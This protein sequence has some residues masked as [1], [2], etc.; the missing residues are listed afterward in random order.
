M[1]PAASGA[2]DSRQ[3]DN[4]NRKQQ[5]ASSPA[6]FSDVT[7]RLASKT[8]ASAKSNAPKQGLKH[9]RGSV[10]GSVTNSKD[11]QRTRGAVAVHPGGA[12]TN[13][14]DAYRSETVKKTEEKNSQGPET[15]STDITSIKVDYYR[16][17]SDQSDTTSKSSK[18]KLKNQQK[19]GGEASTSN[20]QNSKTSVGCGAVF[21]KEGCL[22]SELIQFHI[23]KRLKKGGKMHTKT[24]NTQETDSQS[25]VPAE[26]INTEN[27]TQQDQNLQNEIERLMEENEDFKVAKDV[28]VRLHH[29]LENVEEKRAKTEEENEKLRQQFIEVEITKQALQN[30]LEKAKEVA[31]DVSVRL[32]HELENVEEKRAKT[33]EENEK[34]RQQFI[35]VEITKQALQN[36]LEKA[37]EDDSE[38]LKCQLQFIKEEA[39]LMRKK[40]AKIDKEKDRLEQELQKYRS[41]YGDLDS[42]LPKGEAGGPPTTRESELKL[43]LRL[44]EEEA[45]ILGRKI[46]ELE[47]ENRGLKAEL[48]DLRGD[49][50]AGASGTSFREQSEVSEL[51]QQL[52]LVEDEAELLR[53]NL[54]D[55]ED[56]NKKITTEVNKYKFKAGTH[57]SSRHSDSAKTEVLQEE[58]KAARMQINELSGK[59]M[60]LQYE[61]RV[62]MSNMQRYDLASHL[63]IRGSPRDSDTESDA[64]KR[65]SDDDSR[66][67]HRKR[68]GPIGGESD[69]EEVRN[70]RCLT[71]TRS[72]Y[73]AEGRFLPQ[74]FKDRQ[75]MIDIRM[76]A[77]RLSRTIDR[78]ISD[79]ST[80]ITE[81]R[82][83]VT[84]GDLFGRMDEEDDGSRIREHEL[85]Y[86]INAQMKAFQ[87]ELQTFIDRLEVPKSDERGA[88]EPLSEPTPGVGAAESE[89]EIRAQA[90]KY[91]LQ[92]QHSREK[93]KCEELQKR[94]GQE[95][96]EWIR[97]KEALLRQIAEIQGG[98]NR[99]ILLD[100]KSVL[101]EVQSELKKEETRRSDLQ[102]LYTRDRCAWELERAELKCRI[103]LL[104]HEVKARRESNLNVQ[105]HGTCDEVL[106]LNLHSPTS[107]SSCLNGT[108]DQKLPCISETDAPERDEILCK[109]E[110]ITI[111]TPGGHDPAFVNHFNNKSF[112]E[113][114]G[115]HNN[116]NNTTCGHDKKKYTSTLNAALKEIAKVS[117]E[118]CSYQDEIRQKSNLSNH[119]Y[120]KDKAIEL[121]AKASKY[122][123][124]K[125]IR[126]PKE[127]LKREREEQKRLLADTHTAAMDLRKQLESSERGW[128]REKGELLQRFDMERKEWESQL[129]DMQRKIEELY[130]EVK[131][132]RESNL[133]V[134]EHGT[135]DEVLRLN[136]HSP[137]S[138]SSCL[139]GTTD[140]KLPCISET[141]APERDEILCKLEG[142]TISTPGGHDPAFV[143]HFNNKSFQET[144]GFHNNN[145]NT[146]C[147]HDKKKY[148]STLNAALKEIAKVSE[149]LC[150]YQDEIRQKSNLSNHSNR[151]HSISV[152][153]E[154]EDAQ[155][156]K[157]KAGPRCEPNNEIPAFNPEWSGDL[158]VTEEENNRFNWACMN[159]D[160]SDGF[161]NSADTEAKL[162]PMKKEAPP[163]PPRTTSWYLMNPV[164]Q[165]AV[166]HPVAE[167]SKPWKP[168]DSFSDRKCNSPLVLKK[169]G[170]LLQENEGKTFIDSGIFTNVVPADSKCN[171]GCCHSR[172]SCDISTFG[173]KLLTYQ[174]VQKRFS[175]ISILSF[176]KDDSSDY[177]SPEKPK[178]PNGQFQSTDGK[179]ES[180]SSCSSAEIGGPT[181]GTHSLYSESSRPK[182]NETLAM[183]TAEFNRT[184]FQTD[185]GGEVDKDSLILA[186]LCA[187]ANPSGSNPSC[188]L[189]YTEKDNEKEYFNTQRK[190]SAFSEFIPN[191]HRNSTALNAQGVLNRGLVWVGSGNGNGKPVS[192]EHPLR[193]SHLA[194]YPQPTDSRSNYRVVENIL[195]DYENSSSSRLNSTCGMRQ[196]QNPRSGFA[197]NLIEHLDMLQIQHEA[198]SSQSL[199]PAPS[200]QPNMH[201]HVL[202]EIQEL[203][204]EV[205]ARRESNL[206][207][208]EHGTCDEVLRLNLHSPTSESSCL[209]GTTDQK[210]PCISETDAPER[211]EILCKLEG[212]TISTPGGHDPAFVNH[213]NNKSFQE[214]T[215]FHNNNN[216]TTCG[217]DKK[218]YTS[219]LN[220][221]LKEIAKVSEE[222]CSYQDEIRQKSN[223]SNHSNRTHSISVLEEY[224]DAQNEKN[225]AGPRCEPNNEIPAFNPEWSGDLRVTEEENNRFNWACMNMDTSDGFVNSADTEAKLP[226]MKKEAPP[227][228]PRTTSWYLM[229][230]VT[231]KAVD[232]PVAEVSKPWKPQDSFSDRKCNSPL[233]LKKFGALLQENEGKT[234]I[235]SG[236][237]TNVVPADSKCNIGCCHSRWSCDIST[238]GSKL[239]TYQPVQKRFSDISILSFEKDDSSDYKSP[240]KPKFPN[241]QFQS[242]DGKRESNSSCSS[243]E[244]GGPTSGTH[245]LYSES[246]R[247]K[248]NETL[249]M[250]TAEFNRT[251][252]QTD[253]GGEVDKDSLILA[254]LCANA[255]P[256]GSNP[257]CTL[258]YT[259]KDNEKEYFNTQRKGSAFSE[260]I[261]NR[262]RNST[263]LN[264]QGVLNRGL[265]WVGSSNGNG[266]PVSN[267]HP[268]RPSHLASYPRPTDSRSN[269]RVVENILRDYE[270]SSSSR[271]NST[272]G[273]RQQQ[274]PRSG[275]ADNLIEHLD[276]L[277]IQHEAQ[278][279]QS[280]SPA[281]SRQ[282]NMHNHVL[283]EIQEVSESSALSGKS[284]HKQKKREEAVVS[285]LEEYEDAQNEKNKAGPRCEPNNEIPA[286]NPEWSGDLRVTEDEN[287]RFNWACMNMDMSDGFV[288][289]TDTEAKLPPMKKEAP[290]VPPRTTSWY[291]MN[292]VTQKAVDHPVAEVSKPWKPQDSFSDRKCNSPLVLKKFGALLQENEGKTFIDSGI[293]TNVVP[294]DSKCNIGCCHSRWSCDISTFGSKLLTYQPVQKRFSDIS[295]LSFEKDDSSDYKSPEKPKFPNGQFQS[296]DGKRESNSSC[297][298]AEIGGPTSGTHS[299][300]SE[301][302]RPK[303]NE[304]LAM[305]TAE[306]NRTLFQTDMGG[307]VDK[308]SLILAKLCANANPSGS[309]PSCTLSY[310]EKDN[311]KEYFNTQ[312]KG[313][314]FSEFIPNR[315]R[316]STALNAQGVLNRGL[317]WVGSG[318]GNGKP[319][320]NE[321]PLRPS[322]LASY[323]RPTDSR[324]N[325]RVVENILRD[326]ENSSSSRLNS[327]CGMR[328]QQNP[329]SGFADNLIEHLDML[330]IQHEAQSSQSLSPAPSRQPNMHNHVLLEIQ[331]W[332]VPP[333]A[334][335]DINAVI[336]RFAANHNNRRIVLL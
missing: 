230:P 161:V 51:R 245:S 250:K 60:Q 327:T 221:A 301:S 268:L 138:E 27:M 184:L 284:F 329:R 309:N 48:D 78:L 242:T 37:K 333:E 38:D 117:E 125:T 105:E 249:A 44:V 310:T 75:Q 224:E 91:E 209:N 293:F 126:D 103:A 194:S 21:W 297:S 31:K 144:T 148:T 273:M 271:L 130:H 322:H 232:H 177:K 14:S 237:F 295:I 302:S 257:S 211:D 133:N 62:L 98:E 306:F 58:L 100:F 318:N 65:E 231:Q 84:N 183:K 191:R 22:Q 123:C 63:G 172:W 45:N 330:Q 235:D 267:E 334:I 42:P 287:N 253:M 114:T 205:K 244:I 165:K 192:N 324:S 149:E 208:Q 147:G 217:H 277:Q 226:P 332:A 139:N 113:T 11:K 81:A 210:L 200:R 213:F 275:F 203:Y 145:N 128:G 43:R 196:Q 216:N 288:N 215:G 154:Y 304:T 24:A 239:L 243:A 89:A 1:N 259:E 132:R 135:C 73:S 97:E 13:A 303:K 96:D 10:K 102:Q 212:I 313:S 278:S 151:T 40:M 262:H 314:A 179:R 170:A 4:S 247:P 285:V 204:H 229:N 46:V 79:T 3:S 220:A 319:V 181:S 9:T 142:I 74:N 159:M 246:S 83:C 53:R 30:E 55:I 207:V 15:R 202:L 131:A 291:L 33:E 47:V 294:A 326:Y 241:G 16:L 72:L 137:T 206:N 141:D 116:N 95:K 176:E 201:N 214:T 12:E 335:M 25:T 6:R 272:C 87:K 157:N 260:F 173:S 150:S 320:S 88:E 18:G 286:F 121:E 315:H 252:F 61:N 19:G 77:E 193:P 222:L 233:V 7:T 86:R 289:S 281:P 276:M 92:W 279:S 296:T 155:N 56:Q 264:A 66:P 331:E 256:S 136:L 129:K 17:V 219:T 160:T 34:L 321:H 70:I 36:E 115:F 190:G 178:F 134:Q 171:I 305:K 71:P 163:V 29:E 64:G 323:P 124:E 197:D 76:E 146:T 261:P 90:N 23:N 189:S 290:P 168:Q 143:N 93:K 254:K 164:T 101:E 108:T 269:Y 325:Y 218:K 49:E 169:F 104:Y 187:N 174:P 153:E 195:R 175:D 240:E 336:D 110:G 280:L 198:Q 270:N 316:N 69:S 2:A 106:R 265:V 50:H 185:M 236:I 152:L 120:F 54:A 180:N 234:F 307:E 266:K 52:Q 5:P 67:P 312:R 82:I 85:L 166:D 107:E 292:P 26:E 59:V 186:K 80:I 317:V 283:L 255:N 118:L 39:I 94:H 328:Q 109:L 238:F 140:Q 158:R 223:L 28:S 248:K 199:S 99:R 167:V 308:D 119:R 122:H 299:L 32:H 127:T 298:S 227:V 258:S 282:P 156:E 188:T 311:E 41:F 68:E 274:N 228:P 111:S 57:E 182:K 162:P 225:K 263:A 35:E 112:Q 251:L 20:K 300:Y 8:S